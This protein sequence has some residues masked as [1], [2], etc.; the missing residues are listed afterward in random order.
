MA[1]L[2]DQMKQALARKQRRN[3]QPPNYRRLEAGAPPQS[4]PAQPQ[5]EG[6][7]DMP[8]NVTPAEQAAYE[9]VVLAGLRVIYDEATHDKIMAFLD[10]ADP[11][12]SLGRL[13]ATI[14]IELDRRADNQIPETVI[15]PAAMELMDALAELA[16]VSGKFEVTEVVAENATHVMVTMLAEHYGVDQNQAAQFL[17]DNVP[18]DQLPVAGQEAAQA[19][20]GWRPYKDE[21]GAAQATRQEEDEDEDEETAR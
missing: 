15:L 16:N 11:A 14:L 19:P 9:K 21:A 8:A 7:T 1:L 18:P 4:A 2:R 20:S 5:P 12:T 13:A 10:A 17:Q 3:Q 6:G